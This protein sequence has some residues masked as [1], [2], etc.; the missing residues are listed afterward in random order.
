[1]FRAAFL[2]TLSFGRFWE[3]PQQLQP[4]ARIKRCKDVSHS[5]CSSSS[6]YFYIKQICVA[7]ETNK[8][9]KQK[10]ISLNT[11][12]DVIKL[13]DNGEKQSRHR[14]EPR[15]WWVNS[16]R[17]YERSQRAPRN[18]KMSHTRPMTGDECLSWWRN[19][20]QFLML[21]AHRLRPRNLH[22]S[23]PA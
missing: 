19:R 1:M 7:M 16:G 14:E 8:A 6:K 11:K 21:Y 13:F 18:W 5:Y 17:Q 9:N 3:C 15:I 4:D 12:F 20:G 22:P 2:T 23:K 10:A